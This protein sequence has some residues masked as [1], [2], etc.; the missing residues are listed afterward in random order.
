[1]R[2]NRSLLPSLFCAAALA[3]A[4]TPAHAADKL[5][6]ERLEIKKYAPAA[7]MYL[8]Y[9]DADGRVIS[10][11][12]VSD[13]KLIVDSAEMGM[14]TDV[15]PFET[16]AANDGGAIDLII[17]VE[18]SKPMEEVLED[19]KRGVKLLASSA[20]DKAKVGIITYSADSKPIAPLGAPG[21]AEGAAN[22]IVVDQEGVEVHMLDAVKAAIEQLKGTPA[23]HRKLIVLFSDGIDVNMERKA[24]VQKGKDASDANIV[25]DTI[26]YAPFEPGRLRNLAELSKQSN[27]T[28][29]ACKA[30]NE[31]STQF[32]NVIDEVKKQYVVSF[33]TNIPENDKKQLVWQA[34]IDSG[35]KSAYSNN[36]SAAMT[37]WQRGTKI[38]APSSHWFLWTLLILL[39]VGVL[40]IIVYAVFLREKPEPEPEMVAPA[41]APAPAAPPPVA[42][43]MAIDIGADNKSPVVGWFVG[44]AGKVQDKT[45]KLKA[46]RSLM[47]SSEDCDIKIEDSF[48]SGHHCEVRFEYGAY[49]IIDL[50]STNGIVVNEKKVREHELVDNDILKIGRTEFKFKTIG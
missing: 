31:I 2:R 21:E 34:I 46:G 4:S 32:G 19:M 30:A 6:L 43:T 24:F 13:F 15:K 39:G 42:K 35:G 37:K 25:I 29:R 18:N 8:S 7:R 33:E 5:H 49:K 36:V 17:V 16:V 10:G 23:D 3:A 28:D 50:G 48:A 22:T 27:G 38:E 20:G 11:K 12:S 9:V 1:M 26:G 44:T 41:P 47:G 40:G 14:A 45:F